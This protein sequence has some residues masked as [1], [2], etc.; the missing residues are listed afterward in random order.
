MMVLIYANI[1]TRKPT[2]RPTVRVAAPLPR[3]EVAAL[4]VVA[5][6]EGGAVGTAT[7]AEGAA[8]GLANTILVGAFAPTPGTP[9]ADT[10][11][12]AIDVNVVGNATAVAILAAEAVADGL[13][14]MT[15]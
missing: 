8:V 10:A 14:T 1:V 4:L 5:A 11:A 2:I 9:V 12:A 6:N 15:V 7:A 13:L 3:I